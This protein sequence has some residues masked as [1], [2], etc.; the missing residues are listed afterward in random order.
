M[1]CIPQPQP[2]GN[3]GDPM[4]PACYTLQ[5]VT[6]GVYTIVK[7]VAA[8]TYV[9]CET[10]TRAYHPAI[11][12]TFTTTDPTPYGIA[13]IMASVTLVSYSYDGTNIT[14]TF[15]L[16]G[17][18]TTPDTWI[19]LGWNGTIGQQYVTNP[20]NLSSVNVTFSGTTAQNPTPLNLYDTLYGLEYYYNLDINVAQNVGPIDIH[21][22]APDGYPVA[23]LGAIISYPDY[24][25][26]TQNPASIAVDYAGTSNPITTTPQTNLA[27]NITYSQIISDIQ[28]GTSVNLSGGSLENVAMDVR[29]QNGTLVTYVLTYSDFTTFTQ[30]LSTEPSGYATVTNV[31]FTTHATTAT[32]SQVESFLAANVISYVQFSIEDDRVPSDPFIFITNL[33]LTQSDY[34]TLKATLQTG[35]SLVNTSTVS[36]GTVRTLSQVQAIISDYLSTAN[37]IYAKLVAQNGTVLNPIMT[38]SDWNNLVSEINTGQVLA[39]SYSVIINNTGVTPTETLAQAIAF[40]DANMSNIG[41]LTITAPDGQQKTGVILSQSDYNSLKAITSITISPSPGPSTTAAP[42][43]TFSSLQTWI[44]ANMTLPNTEFTIM[45]T[46]LNLPVVTNEILS[47]SDLAT[48][49]SQLPTGFAISGTTPTSLTPTSSVSA[50]LTAITQWEASHVPVISNTQFSILTSNTSFESNLILS[51]SD[52]ATLQS[53]LP[54]GF[55]ISGNTTT[56]SSPNTT[57]AKIL[58]DIQGYMATG[59]KPSSKIS[60]NMLIGI[61]IAVSAAATI[62]AAMLAKPHEKKKVIV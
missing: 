36:S 51:N 49:K 7:T 8:W 15:S 27:A 4:P 30:F 43:T 26:L 44:N 42:N 34:N 33:I 58:A 2:T 19:L 47:N 14:I 24:T 37:Y 25:S 55:T 18:G 5:S 40:L 9:I 39:S 48:L 1:T 21:T 17:F 57:V 31:N 52:F 29:A 50:S 13:K 11:T 12:E 10:G 20:N 45:D 32:V 46:T 54:T 35:F 61:G 59:Q 16:E 23:I 38:L 28:N 6:N 3:C 60:T 22:N 41:P 53:E 56:S 62:A